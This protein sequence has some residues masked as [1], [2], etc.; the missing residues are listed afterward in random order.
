MSRNRDIEL[1]RY[2]AGEMSMKEEI[3][4]RKRLESESD[5]VNELHAMEQTW[6]H[7]DKGASRNQW[8]SGTAWKKLHQRLM[9][10]GL[11]EKSPVHIPEIRYLPLL[12][13]AAAIL[14]IIAIGIPSVYFGVIRNTVD[15]KVVTQMAD[16]GVSTVDLPDGSR[17][18]L[19][20][21]ASITYPDEFTERRN[22]RL[23][24][25][26]FFEVMSDPMNPFTVRSGKVVVSVLGTS[27]NIKPLGRS[28]EVE[29]LVQTGEV[30]MALDHS[31]SQ[32]TL[33]PGEIGKASKQELLREVL[34]DPNYLSWKTKEFKFVEA[35][36]LEVL[37]ELEESYHVK[38][39]A[40]AA[41]LNGLKITTS[42]SEQSIDAILGTIGAAFGFTITHKEDGYYLSN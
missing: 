12:R 41:E 42:Y 20:E 21:G 16:K 37:R 8:D 14:I 5:Q 25:E 40:D 26:A 38:I 4:F 18:F 29:V 9:E 2:L 1:A 22:V 23:K 28:D 7:F 19:N 30:R 36:L 6:K 34:K 32:I 10:D 35:D 13:I 24:G 27:F 3:A 33:K 15:T 31:K 17:V 11:L 39:H